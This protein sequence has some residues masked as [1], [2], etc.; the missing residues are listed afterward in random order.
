MIDQKGRL[1]IAATLVPEL[2]GSS[3]EFFITSEGGSSVRIYAMQVWS[4]VEE[5]REHLC[6]R[7][8]YFRPGC[9]DE[10]PG[11]GANSDRFADQCAHE[12]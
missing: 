11:Q 1:K 4:Q 8:K 3:T 10:Q 6:S 2:K 7:A 12:G 5:G 9:R